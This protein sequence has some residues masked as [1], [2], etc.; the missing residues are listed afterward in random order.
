MLNVRIQDPK[1]TQRRIRTA[2]QSNARA[3]PVR[4][5]QPAK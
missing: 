5:E 2:A 4:V 1:T 3:T